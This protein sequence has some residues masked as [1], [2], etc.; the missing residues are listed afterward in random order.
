M[1]IQTYLSNILIYCNRHK[2]FFH[3]LNLTPYVPYFFP[4]YLNYENY[5][6]KFLALSNFL[7]A[8]YCS[9]DLT[10][11]TLFRLQKFKT[12]FLQK[13]SSWKMHFYKCLS[14]FCLFIVKGCVNL[15]TIYAIYLKTGLDQSL[16]LR[17]SDQHLCI[18]LFLSLIL[19]LL[20]IQRFWWTVNTFHW[21]LLMLTSQA[22]FQALSYNQ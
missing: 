20:I 5:S 3:N 18:K 2:Y 21:Y 7:Q 9:N 4:F 10:P 15:L 19:Y 12:T 14:Y 16:L 8:C 13:V 17:L 6:S 22:F 1:Q 11:A